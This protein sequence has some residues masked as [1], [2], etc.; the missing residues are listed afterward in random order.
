MRSRV[1]WAW[2]IIGTLL[3]IVAVAAGQVRGEGVL[4][5]S[6]WRLGVNAGVGIGGGCSSGACRTGA[7]P[8]PM[9]QPQRWAQPNQAAPPRAPRPQP[10]AQARTPC[11][12]IV[13]IHSKR[14]DTTKKGTGAV[15]DWR[16]GRALILTCAHILR[17]GFEP[18][19][20][21]SDGSSLPAR[22]VVADALHDCALLEVQTPS[23]RCMRLAA[24]P[25]SSGQV[26]WEGYGGGSYRGSNGR[27]IG[28]DGDFLKIPG[29]GRDGDSGAPVWGLDG[30]LVAIL[31][32]GSQV[33]D[34]PWQVAGP[35]IGWIRGLIDQY[36][37]SPPVY[38]TGQGQAE[39][40]SPIPVPGTAQTE[41]GGGDQLPL[42]PVP[43]PWPAAGPC[44]GLA[45]IRVELAELR[46][47]SVDLAKLPG[48]PGPPGPQGPPGATPL[49]KPWYLRTVDARPGEVRITELT[50]GDT[51]TLK[52]YDFPK[53]TPE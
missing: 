37:K 27:V 42:I 4:D 40:T 50:P 49:I 48:I 44:T 11:P 24:A 21:F 25:P 43:D 20:I 39:N 1:L 36:W 6:G 34:E 19:V 2:L 15:V 51:I 53:A 47:A 28:I 45:E 41:P 23:I 5:T 32:D 9:S 29:Q 16:D 26:S 46:K 35:H 31:N 30:G 52:L 13:Q 18:F 8:P 33:A 10:R 22:I 12:A 17:G 7:C 38:G 14:G 3:M